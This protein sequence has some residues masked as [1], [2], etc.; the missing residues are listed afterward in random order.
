VIT[1]KRKAR[2]KVVY[3]VV[4]VQGQKIRGVDPWRD[5]GHAATTY[6]AACE[7]AERLRSETVSRVYDYEFKAVYEKFVVDGVVVDGKGQVAR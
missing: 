3:R 4:G 1:I 6:M 5:Y 2:F 7:E